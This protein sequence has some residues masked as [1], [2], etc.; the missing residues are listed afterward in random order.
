[1][2]LTL[3]LTRHA[4]SSWGDPALDDFDRPLNRRGQMSARAIG[5]WLVEQDA[6]PDEVI[7]S[8]A[9]RTVD[10]WALI[11]GQLPNA[12]PMR[13]DPA[14]YLSGPEATLAVLRGATG[15]TVMLI[16]HNPGF[17]D[18]AGRISTAPADHP[19]FGD[20]P[21]GATAVIDFDVTAWGDVGWGQGQVR[22]FVV[23]R[24][25]TD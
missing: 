9:R 7:V 2:G 13:S 20:Y 11:S 17:G 15:Q 6:S 18:F 4:K 8:G 19:R 1:M 14:L 22:A 16:G 12:A 24:D 23:P 25:L 10:T 3:I 5:D 21:T